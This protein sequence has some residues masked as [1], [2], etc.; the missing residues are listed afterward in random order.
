MKS[1]QTIEE[2]YKEN[3]A[4]MQAVKELVETTKRQDTDEALARLTGTFIAIEA[5][6]ETL[7]H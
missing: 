5:K 7:W 6:R 1:K 2:L 4:L 3:Q